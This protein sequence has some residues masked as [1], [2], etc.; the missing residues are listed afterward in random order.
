MKNLIA[1]I[2]AWFAETNISADDYSDSD[3][4][5]GVYTR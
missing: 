2:R 1:K 3:T 4:I 5:F